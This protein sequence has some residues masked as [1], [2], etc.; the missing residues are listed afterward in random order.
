MGTALCHILP[1]PTALAMAMARPSKA[2]PIKEIPNFPAIALPGHARHAEP[3][4]EAEEIGPAIGLIK[5]EWIA[6]N[7]IIHGVILRRLGVFPCTPARVP[8]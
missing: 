1:F 3:E 8:P 4:P 7:L 5:K 6:H 2:L